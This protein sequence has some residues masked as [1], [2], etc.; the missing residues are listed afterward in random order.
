[1]KTDSSIVRQLLQLAILHQQHGSINPEELENT[2]RK[3][4]KEASDLI[5]Q[6]ERLLDASRRIR[7]DSLPSELKGIDIEEY[8][9]LTD[10]F[11]HRAGGRF[12]ALSSRPDHTPFVEPDRYHAPNPTYGGAEPE[13]AP[14]NHDVAETAIHT[15]PPSMPAVRGHAEPNEAASSV[16]GNRQDGNSTQVDLDVDRYS[17]FDVNE[18]EDDKQGSSHQDREDAQ[19]LTSPMTGFRYPAGETE[20]RRSGATAD[21]TD[22][23][24]ARL[25]QKGVSPGS[26]FNRLV[27]SAG[28]D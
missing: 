18:D 19:R 3:Y 25:S 14:A 20:E 15:S 11:L 10:D 22:Q 28:E 13:R 8:L 26:P 23:M 27:K 1:M 16:S 17:R 2:A 21:P 9:A 12:D 7:E 5:K 24:I 4:Q 6:S